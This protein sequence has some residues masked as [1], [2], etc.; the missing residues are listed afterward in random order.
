[1]YRWMEG[2]KDGSEREGKESGNLERVRCL[3][4][5]KINQAVTR[6]NEFVDR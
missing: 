4:A 5:F 3:H 1:M 6:K 2:W